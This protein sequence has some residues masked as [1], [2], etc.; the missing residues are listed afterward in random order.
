MALPM[1]QQSSKPITLKPEWQ[2]VADRIADNLIYF[3]ENM[4]YNEERTAYRAQVL[5]TAHTGKSEKNQLVIEMHGAIMEKVRGHFQAKQT[6]PASVCEP[7]GC[8]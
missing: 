1:E 5:A 2:A 3:G 7:R 6:S 4:G 8:Q